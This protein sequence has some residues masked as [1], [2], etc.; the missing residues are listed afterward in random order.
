MLKKVLLLLFLALSLEVYSLDFSDIDTQLNKIEFSVN[1][2]ELNNSNLTTQLLTL[3]TQSQSDKQQ[4]SNL[5]TQLLTLQTQSASDSERLITVSNS[6]KTQTEKYQTLEKQSQQLE[7]SL[8]FYQTTTVISISIIA[9][10]T[11]IKILI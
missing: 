3:Q 2:I 5:T 1:N 4:L 6:L 8:K 7:K 10:A 11:A 9:V